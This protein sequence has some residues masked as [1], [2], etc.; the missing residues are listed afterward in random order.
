[1]SIFNR[2]LI[3]GMLPAILPNGERLRSETGQDIFTPL[4][5][6]ILNPSPENRWLEDDSFPSKMVPCFSVTNSFIFEGGYPSKS[7][8]WKSTRG[9]W[10]TMLRK[11]PE[12]WSCWWGWWDGCYSPP[13]KYY[14][15]K[16]KGFFHLANLANRLGCGKCLRKYIDETAWWRFYGKHVL[17]KQAGWLFVKL[18]QLPE[19]WQVSS[20]INEVCRRGLHVKENIVDGSWQD[21]FLNA[22]LYRR[23]QLEN[24]YMIYIYI[25]IHDYM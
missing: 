4:K 7:Q 17:R 8:R 23:K 9:N 14:Q 18:L 22:L 11:V 1:M 25:I 12:R 5:T 20:I 21:C 2:C 24:E 10:C 15:L 16:L 3:V 6:N 19:I 13:W